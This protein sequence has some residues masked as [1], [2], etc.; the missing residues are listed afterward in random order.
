[1]FYLLSVCPSCKPPVMYVFRYIRPSTLLGKGWC[2]I[3]LECLNLM[4]FG[5]LF[6][7]ALFIRYFEFGKFRIYFEWMYAKNVRIGKFRIFYLGCLLFQT[8]MLE[9]YD[10]KLYVA[11]NT[12][13]P[14]CLKLRDCVTNSNV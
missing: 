14:Y 8:L 11:Y 10:M 6:L 5:W 1:M 12:F 7:N 3:V 2:G 4:H 9:M 13:S